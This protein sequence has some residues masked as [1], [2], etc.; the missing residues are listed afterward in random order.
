[1]PKD[2]EYKM[3]L[4]MAGELEQSLYMSMK[5]TKKE[6]GEIEKQVGNTLT[7]GEMSIWGEM[8]KEL[9]EAES[10]F[11]SLEKA[12]KTTF[13][14]LAAM[15]S[16]AGEQIATALIGSIHVGSEFESAFDGVKKSVNAT[17]MEMEQLRDDLRTMAREVIP[18]TASELAAI[19]EA[20]GKLGIR[21]ENIIGF[22]ETMANMDAATNL[23]SEEA[24]A[25]FVQF[26]NIVGMSQEHFHNLGSTMV[27]LSNNMETTE[28][29]IMSMGMGIAAAGNQ[30]NLSSAE[31]MAYS[32]A[33]ASMGVE[34]EAGG[35]AFS[36][37][38]TKLQLAA[39]TGEHLQGYA[40]VAGM[41]GKQFKQ[42]FEQ[43][44]AT[45]I[46]AFLAGLN[47]TEKHGKSA[48]T[49]LAELGMTEA[50]LQDTLLRA[51]DAS[52]MFEGTLGMASEAWEEN[53]ALTQE[54]QQQYMTFEN[55]AAMTKNKITDLGISV[56]DELQPGLMEG[57]GLINAFIDS[58]SGQDDVIGKVIE[59]IVGKM[60]TMAREMKAAGEAVRGFAE[61]LLTVGGWLLDNPGVLVGAIA[62][63]A[64]ALATYKVASE[65][66]AV[67]NALTALN[68]VSQGILL[69]SG[70]AAVITGIGTA[71]A[72]AADDAKAANLD[73]HF[74]NI[75]LSLSELQE[76]AAAIIQSDSL[77]A[78]RESILAL[79]EADRIA[80][81]IRDKTA[82]INKTNWKISMG[83]ELDEAEEAEY[84]SQIE[85]FVNSTQDF[86]TEKQYGVNL[87]VSVLLDVDPE[88]SDLVS[89]I[90][91]FY[92]SK[93]EELQEIG[94]ELKNL[95][96]EGFAKE[97]F[98]IDMEEVA[99]LQKQML[100]IQEQLLGAEYDANLEMIKT[101][102]SG[103]DLDAESIMN[104]QAE[105]GEMTAAQTEEYEKMFIESV[106]NV[107]LLR[108]EIGEDEYKKRVEELRE[109]YFRKVEELQSKSADFQNQVI[110]EQY[111]GEIGDLD[112]NEKIKEQLEIALEN[113][114]ANGNAELNWKADLIYKG[115]DFNLDKSTQAAL[116]ELWETRKEEFL[117]QL[118]TMEEKKMAGIEITEEEREII[119]DTATLGALAGDQ[120]AIYTLMG[121]EIRKSPEY[122]K[123]IDELYEQGMKIPET[124][125]NGVWN[126][127]EVLEQAFDGI[128]A[129]VT[130]KGFEILGNSFVKSTGE[131]VKQTGIQ[132]GKNAIYSAA[133]KGH[134][135]GGIFT[136]PHVA[137]FAEDGPEAAIPLDGSP[138]AINLWLKTGELL[139]IDGLSGGPEPLTASIE[140]AAYSGQKETVI[141]V[142]NSRTIQFYGQAPSK[143]ELEQ[144]LEDEDE[145]FAQMMKRYLGNNRRVSFA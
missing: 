75:T 138:N 125:A 52:A 90:N 44:A 60:P 74:G 25:G 81:S 19:A 133:T 33:L 127:K 136:V 31:I 27:E 70:V 122:K 76:M 71:V 113:I 107:G 21:N 79:D 42:A 145:K 95:I 135:E 143:G 73:A 86:V 59:S 104:L 83:I 97:D 13:N 6:L 131:D 38:L 82:E 62:G 48:I 128:Y 92:A 12:A 34:A 68:P 61:P 78:V 132:I 123:M 144:V 118:K 10:V 65:I 3:A 47:D 114:A 63:I 77:N 87:A 117:L 116:E 120:D 134:A 121:E 18:V 142:D 5:L 30:M 111:Q 58:L 37:F 15:A 85:S 115:M 64:T 130:D 106:Q 141:Q 9:K 105:L 100:E 91:A 35:N 110:M 29:D 51:S 24:A 129:M 50:N 32:A 11:S 89:E 26:A 40:S 22:T 140:E 36:Q 67:M 57:M 41:T 93:Q 43:D 54:A 96:S 80:D 14:S 16:V 1:M 53:T 84:I 20:G 112:V 139:G 49:V 98:N 108:Q 4:K 124:I 8:N 45:A 119:I 137:W 2:E 72:K 55:Q 94:S 56:Y 17:G 88:N 103:G 102:Y 101:R 66:T 69:L 46:N 99:N 7:A 126:R 39:E 109:G 28:T 23:N